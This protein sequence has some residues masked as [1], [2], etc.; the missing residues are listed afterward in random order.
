[1]SQ[2]AAAFF[3]VDNTIIRGASSYHLARELYRRGFFRR[4][5][6]IFFAGHALYYFFFG[7]N[8]QHM[9][10]VRARALSIMEGHS[11]AEILAVA[12]EVYEQVL[13]HRIFPGARELIE[14]H[15]QAGDQVWIVTA[16]PRE[17]G[18]LVARRLGLTGALGT[19]AAEQDGIYTGELVGDMMHGVHK[20]AGV[21]MV[22]ETEGLDLQAC[23]AY[24][25]SSHDIPM[26][27]T[28]GS[29][30]AINPDPRLRLIAAEIGW[31]V[32][33]F[34]RRRRNVRGGL[35]TASRAGMVWAG[36]HA[37]RALGRLVRREITRR[38]G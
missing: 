17:V 26:L 12:E 32:R 37:L 25:D 19:V 31:P 30:C 33:D 35:R 6:I 18:E 13:A 3:D 7:E 11:V 14:S 1:M 16:A 22:A 21:R 36:A 5:D 9:N 20:A 24:G 15:L 34:R 29:P 23:S 38:R 27:R 8:R 28:V 4:R 10:T 2:P